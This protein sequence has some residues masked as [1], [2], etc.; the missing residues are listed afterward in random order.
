[1][2]K[3]KLTALDLGAK[4]I[5]SR[6]Q[7]KNVTGG[8]AGSGSGCYTCKEKGEYVYGYGDCT[9]NAS[10]DSGTCSTYSC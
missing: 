6:D 2:K 7:L 8:D 10:C 3:L 9:T 4:E 5:L 1:M